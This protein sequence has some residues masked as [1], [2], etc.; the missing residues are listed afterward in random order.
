MMVVMQ[1][2]NE[3]HLIVIY[4]LLLVRGANSRSQARHNT[5]PDPSLVTIVPVARWIETAG[6]G[7]ASCSS[8]SGAPE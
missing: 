7:I 5:L 6:R 2:F 8:I 3:V 1:F 4:G